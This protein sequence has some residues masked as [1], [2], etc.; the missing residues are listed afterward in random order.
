MLRLTD[1]GQKRGL[2]ILY[3]RNA[4][5]FHYHPMTLDA[6]CQRMERVGESA[7]ILFIRNNPVDPVKMK[8]HCAPDPP[9]R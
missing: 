5:T 6:F 3:N 4:A 7:V 2:R 9:I 8:A 1:I